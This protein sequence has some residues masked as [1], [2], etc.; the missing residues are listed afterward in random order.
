MASMVGRPK[1]APMPVS[2]EL[3]L[4]PGATPGQYGWPVA[5]SLETP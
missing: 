4:S 3:T 2:Y 1:P 5:L